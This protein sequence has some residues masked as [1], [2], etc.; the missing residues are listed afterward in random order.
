[1]EGIDDDLNERLL[2]MRRRLEGKLL[3]SAG[4]FEA[5][6]FGAE[7][8]VDNFPV[9]SDDFGAIKLVVGGDSVAPKAGAYETG[10]EGESCGDSVLGAI[11]A[12]LIRSDAFGLDDGTEEKVQKVELMRGLVDKVPAS[13]N[14]GLNVPGQVLRFVI[15]WAGRDMK[16]GGY[17][18]WLANGIVLEEVADFKECGQRAAIIGGKKRNSCLFKCLDD[19]KAFG[20]LRAMGFSR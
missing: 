3:R 8:G 7:G 12:S 2:N 15:A 17:E 6:R 1:M 20:M 18:P 11:E 16:F 10:L 5:D 19:F 14:L 13:G 9:A 4:R